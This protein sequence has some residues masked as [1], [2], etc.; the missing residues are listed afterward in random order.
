MR[1]FGHGIYLQRGAV[2]TVIEDTH[3]EGEMRSTDAILEDESGLVAEA[4]YINAWTGERIKPGRIICLAEDGIRAYDH[5]VRDVQIVNCT[6]KNMRGGVALGPA[7]GN[8]TVENTELTGCSRGFTVPDNGTIRNCEA[9]AKYGPVLRLSR[10][11]SSN[12]RA[13]ITVLRSD[14]DFPP[15]ALA[16]INGRNHQ[17]HL[18][19]SESEK[20]TTKLPIVVG[21]TSLGYINSYGA[22]NVRLINE[23][24]MPVEIR[25]NVVNC[26]ILNDGEINT[27]DSTDE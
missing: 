7:D 20:L 16:Y 26:T 8:I 15:E 19:P 13:D 6:I 2:K 21:Y 5:D 27:S 18:R 12:I 9:D 24:N 23:T 10:K 11:E 17:I 14:S 22:E 1:S 4:E 3:I 25:E